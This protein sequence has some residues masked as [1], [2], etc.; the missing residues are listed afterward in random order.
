[1]VVHW[2]MP[3]N[4]ILPVIRDAREDDA[5]AL[6]ALMRQLEER[7]DLLYEPGERPD[8][9]ALVRGQIRDFSARPNCR[10]LVAEAAEGPAGFLTLEGGRVRRRA[11]VGYLIMSVHPDWHGR[12]VGTA[13]LAEAVTWAARVGLYRI[14]LIVLEGNAAGMALYRKMGF[15]E[16]GRLRGYGVVRGKRVDGFF[17]ARLL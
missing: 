2:E 7:F 12:G 15:E 11:G 14:E 8:D 16:E 13:L 5:P 6:L 9:P 10:F 17:M 4:R 3:V 1:M